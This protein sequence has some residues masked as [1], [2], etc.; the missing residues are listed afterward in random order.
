[1]ITETF[2]T[3]PNASSDLRPHETEQLTDAAAKGKSRASAEER[4]TA[5]KVE[6]MRD[7]T[8][9]GVDGAAT[10]AHAKARPSPGRPR[11]GRASQATADTLAHAA[12]Y[13]RKSDAGSVMA[14]ARQLVKDNPGIAMLG[15]A[16]IGFVLARAWSRK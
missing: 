10:S 15:A 8:A 16:I 7:G 14:D 6:G 3:A 2:S 13:I 12:E 11:G 5:G 1:M 4:S 9:E